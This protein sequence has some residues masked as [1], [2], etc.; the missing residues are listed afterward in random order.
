M[1]RSD[2][3]RSITYTHVMEITAFDVVTLIVAI[4]GAFMGLAALV[5]NVAEYR[6]TGP[7]VKVEIKAAMPS[8]GMDGAMTGPEDVW[9]QHLDPRFSDRAVAI[10]VRNVGR[11]PATVESYQVDIAEGYAFSYVQS[12]LG[13]PVP[14]RMEAGEAETWFIEFDA[15][16]AFKDAV[17]ATVDL[18]DHTVRA[19]LLLGDGRRVKSKNSIAIP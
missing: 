9:S 1:R 18:K 10:K 15:V 16:K 13:P 2:C 3:S 8:T 6:L 14:H 5:W 4:V 11:F 17:G 12:L 19:S 7:R